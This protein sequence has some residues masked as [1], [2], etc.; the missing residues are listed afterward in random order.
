MMWFTMGVSGT[1]PCRTAL[2][3]HLDTSFKHIFGLALGIQ[4]FGSGVLGV[5]IGASGSE[6]KEGVAALT[7]H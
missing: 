5:G 3:N 6:F 1:T 4:I 2:S 7:D